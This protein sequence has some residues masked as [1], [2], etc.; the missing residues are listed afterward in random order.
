MHVLWNRGIDS[1]LNVLDVGLDINAALIVTTILCKRP[2]PSK[3][4]G[5][6]SRQALS[7]VVQYQGFYLG[8][9]H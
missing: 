3:Q 4:A 5:I 2:H 6:W 7:F 9:Q 8:T 1:N